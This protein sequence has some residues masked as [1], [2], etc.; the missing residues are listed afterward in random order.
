MEGA[1]E[2]AADRV[3]WAGGVA[4]AEGSV[5]VHFGDQSLTGARAT[6]DGVTLVVEQGLYRRADGAFAFDRAEVRPAPGTAVLV[7]VRVTTGGASIVAERLELGEERWTA[8]GATV[9]PCECADGG[10]PALSFTAARIEVVP[11]RV[12]IVH[13]G[14]ARVFEV[15][16]LPVPYWRVPLDPHRFRLL[17]PEVG[18]GSFG[19]SAGIQARGGVGDWMIQGGPAWRYDRG[20]RGELTVTGPSITGQ[21]ALGWDALTE[22][23]RGAGATRGGVDGTVR[24]GWDA[25]WVSDADYLAD[26]A[27]DYVSRGTR[28]RDSRAVFGLG[29]STLDVWVPDDGSA[30]TL[31]R[32]RV[33]WEIGRGRAASVTPRVGL[34]AVGTFDDLAPLGEIGVGARAVAR[35]EWLVAELRGDLAGRVLVG[36]TALAVTP[37]TLPAWSDGLDRWGSGTGGWGD[38]LG[39]A[40]LDRW[41]TGGTGLAG[42]A[43]ADVAVPVWSSLGASRTQ[44][45]PG[46]RA[47]ARAGWAPG[48][49]V[50]GAVRVGPA[51]RATTSD[52]DGGIGLDAALLQD[53]TGWRPALALDVHREKVAVRLQADPDVQAGEARWMPGPVTLAVGS[54]RASALWLG[55]GDAGVAIGRLRTGAGLAWNLGEGTYAGAD[56]R[57]GYDD[58]CASAMVT[59]RFAPDRP[60]PD[61]GFAATLRR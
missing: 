7:D 61:F 53:G 55:W 52:A 15:P 19:P 12:V 56:A 36:D 18:W 21:G 10:P 29:P 26:Y 45:W 51:V 60:L 5:A 4:V 2:V 14:V 37:A 59:A 47:E 54:A 50:E 8:D 20:G 38:A 33:A 40:P 25:T 28:W 22:T 6:W 31:A 23:V 58:G 32:E 1:I 46:V 57:I 41:G 11:D 43:S 35:T 9:V 24:L 48:A 17:L 34:A 27:V 16:I 13:G 42:L 39:H 3:E 44:W 49:P 30:G